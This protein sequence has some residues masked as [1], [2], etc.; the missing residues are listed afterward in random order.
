MSH[1]LRYYFGVELEDIKCFFGF[2]GWCN[3]YNNLLN[4]VDQRICLNCGKEQHKKSFIWW[5]K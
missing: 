5:G 3:L 4:R 1:K 2:H